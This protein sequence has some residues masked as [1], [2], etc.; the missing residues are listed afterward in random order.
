VQ[1]ALKILRKEHP[2]EVTLHQIALSP[3]GQEVTLVEITTATGPVPAIFTVANLEGSSPLATEGALFLAQM[4]L[5]SAHYTR[6]LK[7]FIL[8]QPNP[9]AAESFFAPLRWERSVNRKPVNDDADDQTDEDGPDDLNGDGW[10]TLMRVADPEGTYIT[11]PKDPR[12]LVPANPAKG[13]RGRYKLYTEG[14]DNDGDGRYNE[15]AP[16]G[17][18]PAINFPH[19]FKMGDKQA[20]LWPGESPEVYGMMEFIFSHPE[21]AMA[22]TLGSADFCMTPPPGGRRGGAS[23]EN[24]RVP[25]RLA[26]RYGVDPE[27]SYSMGEIVETL[28]SAMPAGAREITPDMVAGMLGLGAVVNPLDEDLRFYTALSEKYKAFLKSRGATGERMAAP[29]DKEG[30]FE[31]W[32]Y[33]HLGIPSFAMN[34]FTPPVLPPEG[35]AAG[36]NQAAPSGSGKE[37]PGDRASTPVANAGVSSRGDQAASGPPP[38]LRTGTPV[39]GTETAAAGKEEKTPPAG[40]KTTDPQETQLQLL[41]WIDATPEVKGF[42]P[43]TPVTHPQLG[44]AEVGGFAPYVTTTPPATMKD[45]LCR[46]QIPWLLQLSQQLPRLAI[47][48]EKVTPLGDHLFRL[49]IF[50]ENRGNLPWPIAMGTRNRQ[51]APVIL[52]LEGEKFQILEGYKRAPLEQIGSNQVKKLSW[53]IKTEGKTTLKARIDTPLADASVRE[54]PLG[55]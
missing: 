39:A 6:Q 46:L 40:R 37:S 10:I 5:D 1:T 17:I 41:R 32:A 23:Y 51:P 21:I 36:A 31:L 25:A 47:H 16:G 18:N 13:E 2:R 34:L 48:S 19:L 20:G 29:A 12:L 30:S 50:V 33:Y 53:V 27:K 24:I 4:L 35:N 15:D 26:S 42:V 3:G 55:K 22:F 45:S 7:W 14:T 9:D 38:G 44:Q 8:P 28:K 11:S 54:I 52:L 49:E 43:W